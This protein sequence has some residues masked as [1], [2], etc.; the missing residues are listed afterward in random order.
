MTKRV[1]IIGAGPSGLPAIKNIS[2]AGISVV[3]QR[4]YLSMK[5]TLLGLRSQITLH[6]KN[7]ETIFNRMLSTLTCTVIYNSIR[8]LKAVL[9]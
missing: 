5:I 8:L 6:M 1:C 9:G 3:V 7:L 2:E 4:L